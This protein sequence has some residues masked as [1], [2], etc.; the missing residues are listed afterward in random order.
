MWSADDSGTK[1]ALKFDDFGKEFDQSMVALHE[2]AE[3]S[4]SVDF[5]QSVDEYHTVAR[6]LLQ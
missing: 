4:V 5:I 6:L 1:P 3:R 2:Q